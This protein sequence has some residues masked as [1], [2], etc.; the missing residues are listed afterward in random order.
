[1]QRVLLLMAAVAFMLS[2][3]GCACQPWLCGT[4]G[5]DGMSG[6]GGAGGPGRP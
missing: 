6:V 5:P 2:L 3:G 1:M 4:G